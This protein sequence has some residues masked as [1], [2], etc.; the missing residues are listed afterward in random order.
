M[1]SFEETLKKLFKIDD[2]DLLKVYQLQKE[3]DLL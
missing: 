3:A 1:P 2:K